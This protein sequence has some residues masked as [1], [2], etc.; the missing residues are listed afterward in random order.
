MKIS[1]TTSYPHPVLAPWSTDIL[2]A[3]IEAN[4]TFEENSDRGAVSIHCAAALD[5][6]DIVK[7]IEKGSAE[8]GFFIKCQETGLRRVQKFGFPSG[9]HQFAPGA[10]LG[11][12]QLRPMVWA[13]E[14]IPSYNPVG[15]HPEFEHGCD[16]EPGEILA[17][18]DEQVMDVTRP[19][20]PSIESIFEI[21]SSDQVADGKFEVDTGSDRIT[22]QMSERMFHLV[23]SLR[24]TDDTT[25]AVIMNGLYVPVVMQV[26]GELAEAGYEQFEQYRWLHPFRA[27][28]ELAQVDIKKLDLLNDAQLLL[29]QPFCALTVL[30]DDS[31]EPNHE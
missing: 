21:T 15:A 30:I 1:E 23:Q 24:A 17:L 27:R 28:C 10:L 9:I 8:F 16:V 14:R 12:V 19:P 13:T 26:L 4:I 18:D 6:P 5:H 20:L 11:R 29:G 25:R 2:G 22:V 31:E 7:L 3:T